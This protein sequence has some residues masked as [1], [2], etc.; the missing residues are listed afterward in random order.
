MLCAGWGHNWYTQGIEFEVTVWTESD[1]DYDVKH[2]SRWEV[3][4]DVIHKSRW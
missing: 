4:Y 2:K 1:G 3:A